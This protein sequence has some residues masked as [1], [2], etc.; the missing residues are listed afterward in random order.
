MPKR[1][2]AHSASSLPG[3][4]GDIALAQSTEPGLQIANSVY[5]LNGD[6]NRTVLQGNVN[7]GLDTTLALNFI[8]A[9]YTFEQQVLGA[10]YSISAAVPFGR[11]KL[12]A[13][14]EAA[15]ARRSARDDSFHFADI[16]LIPLELTWTF[17][18]LSIKFGQA[19]Y[20]PLGG[21]DD[22]EVVNIGTQSLGLRFRCLGN[23]FQHRHR[24]RIVV[25]AR[26]SFQYGEQRHQL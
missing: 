26:H 21:Y 14:I 18:P 7:A 2:K 25:G 23:L 6:V 19:V 15:G 5:F 1:R 13:T 10:D 8:A 22:D 9:G 17:D 4:A 16:A 20:V 24:N 3:A 11:A 12:T